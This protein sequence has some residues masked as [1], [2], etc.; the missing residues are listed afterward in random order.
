WL[1]RR[2]A[3]PRQRRRA[4]CALYAGAV[5]RILA[6][7][8]RA[9]E[10]IAG[11][12]QCVVRRGHAVRDEPDVRGRHPQRALARQTAAAHIGGLRWTRVLRDRRYPGAARTGLWCRRSRDR[13]TRRDRESNVRTT[14]LARRESALGV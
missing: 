8:A 14:L 2:P 12:P 4:R 1:C 10:G 6:A 5:G 13:G 9:G 3:A 7:R 11:R